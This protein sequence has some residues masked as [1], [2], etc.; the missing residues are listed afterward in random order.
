MSATDAQLPELPSD[1]V[2]VSGGDPQKARPGAKRQLERAPLLLRQAALV[3]IAAGLLPW[4]GHNGTWVTFGLA[5]VLVALGGWMFLES[6]K[7]RTGER[8]SGLL[9]PLARMRFGPPPGQKAKGAAALLAG[10]PTALHVLAW[11]V[12]LAGL[13]TPLFDPAAALVDVAERDAFNFGKAITEVG[14]FAWGIATFVHIAAYE[15]GG[16]FSPM[17]PF[18]FLAPGIGGLFVLRY[19]LMQDEKNWISALGA[20]LAVISGGLAVYTI[21]VAMMQ[22]KKEGD[23]KRNAALE[24]RRAQRK[25]GSSR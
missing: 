11:V 25:S 18:V 17:Y 23:A 13:F 3:L 16:G 2:L 9:A 6:I 22:A 24:A 15:R 5:K 10:I 21:T 1:A 7:V 20:V 14:L 8:V 12:T 4:V 19:A